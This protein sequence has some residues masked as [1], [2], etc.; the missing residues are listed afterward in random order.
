MSGRC[1]QQLVESIS[2]PSTGWGKIHR[3]CQCKLQEDKGAF[4][5]CTAS[6]A[7]ADELW[8][9]AEEIF[10]NSEEDSAPSKEVQGVHLIEQ[11]YLLDPKAGMLLALSR[12][13]AFQVSSFHSKGSIRIIELDG[14]RQS[15]C[16]LG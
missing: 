14:F 12:L 1:R 10:L 5:E 13:A 7:E 3:G 9:A 11:G 15:N 4:P 16:G 2:K 8:K 6:L